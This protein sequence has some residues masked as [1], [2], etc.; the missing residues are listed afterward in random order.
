MFRSRLP[1]ARQL[2]SRKITTSLRRVNA[3]VEIS[4]LFKVSINYGING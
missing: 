4:S 2:S 1:N 3:A